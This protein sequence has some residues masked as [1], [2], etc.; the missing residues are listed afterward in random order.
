MYLDK[1]KEKEG[2]LHQTGI[3]QF[4][5]CT[6]EQVAS[7]EDWYGHALPR[8]YREFL[9]WM[10]SWGGG[11]LIGSHCFYGELK[12]IQTWAKDLLREDEYPGTLPEDAFVF[13]MHQGY[14]FYFFRCHEGEDPPVYYYLESLENEPLQASFILKFA[15]FSDF[16]LTAIEDSL[17]FSQTMTTWRSQIATSH[18]EKAKEIYE[19]EMKRREMFRK[20]GGE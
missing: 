20:L 18:P 2:N 11:F 1:A 13:W 17:N 4:I 8:A 3:A 14:Q 6:E 9:F 16:L 12:D 19:R 15:H 10:G 5:P 7:L